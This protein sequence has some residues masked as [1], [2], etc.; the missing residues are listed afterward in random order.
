MKVRTYNSP[1]NWIGF[2]EIFDSLKSNQ[3]EIYPPHNIIEVNDDESYIELAVAGFSIQDLEI[4]TEKSE[5]RIT[6]KKPNS[7]YLDSQF[8]H[9][10]ISSK[11]FTK[12]FRLGEHV[13]AKEASCEN[14]LLKIRLVREV[15]EAMKPK[16]IPINSVGEK[17]V[18]KG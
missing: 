9:R 7:K 13:F 15:P 14:G 10:G 4:E 6:G 16:T 8:R 5:L 11:G 12:A 3:V 18:L 1:A 17:Q 2:N